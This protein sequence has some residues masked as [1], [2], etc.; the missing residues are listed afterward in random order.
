MTEY[1]GSKW[2]SALFSPGPAVIAAGA[3][4]YT[5]GHV[6]IGRALVAPGIL[7]SAFLVGNLTDYLRHA[8]VRKAEL[9]LLRP[10]VPDH[11][12]ERPQ[13]ADDSSYPGGRPIRLDDFVFTEVP[14]VREGVKV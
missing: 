13:R 5:H 11:R 1:D 9:P 10:A 6:G 3:V 7:L 4:L 14:P 2:A 8:V 12:T